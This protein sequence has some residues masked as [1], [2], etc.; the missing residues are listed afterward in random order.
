MLAA[1]SLVPRLSSQ[2]EESLGMRLGCLY[3][4]EGESP[5]L[6][7]V[8]YEAFALVLILGKVD[9]HRLRG[10]GRKVV[11]QARP[12][13]VEVGLVCKTRRKGKPHV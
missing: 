8:V 1:C 10:K 3:P 11:S 4:V 9:A 2:K 6:L 13:S 7:L 5:V 12:T